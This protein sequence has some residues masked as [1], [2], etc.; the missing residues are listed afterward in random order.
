M[1]IA[2]TPI[3]TS[4]LLYS[5]KT[6]DNALHRKDLGPDGSVCVHIDVAQN[7]IGNH[8]CGPEPL[9]EYRLYPVKSS[10]KL[11][12]VPFHANEITE[13]RLYINNII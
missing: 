13:E 9:E 11:R 3:S 12:L 6:L 2:E 10:L 7:G 5:A 4:A 1:V 8:S